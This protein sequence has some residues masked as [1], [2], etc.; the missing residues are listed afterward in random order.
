MLPDFKLYYKTT[1]IKRAWYWHKNK[2]ITQWNRT[3]GPVTDPH[4]YGQLI[5]TKKSRIYAREMPVSSIKDVGKTEQPCAKQKT[6]SLSY[7][8]HKN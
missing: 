4:M 8:I 7:T 6:G 3:E 1:A 5:M 2:P